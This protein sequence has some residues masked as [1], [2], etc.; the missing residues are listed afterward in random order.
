M[1]TA[2]P[3]LQKAQQYLRSAALLLEAGD[4][5]S[6]ASRSY[7]AMFYAAHAALAQSGFAVTSGTGIRSAFVE[8]FV[9]NGPFPE[10]AGEALH[11][12]YEMQQTADYAPRPATSEADAERLLQEAEAF[13]NSAAQTARPGA[14]Q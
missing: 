13:V 5:D 2:K 14:M 6:S 11:R 10:R 7:F 4:F 12:A 8:R 9:E 1:E 3:L